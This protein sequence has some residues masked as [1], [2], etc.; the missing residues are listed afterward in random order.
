MEL[1]KSQQTHENNISHPPKFLC[2]HLALDGIVM[3]KPQ[4]YTFYLFYFAGCS[5]YDISRNPY[6]LSEKFIT[7]KNEMK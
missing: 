3:T 5:I 7:K 4:I 1:K 2:R 6:P